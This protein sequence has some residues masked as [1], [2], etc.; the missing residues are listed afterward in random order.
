MAA[1][2]RGVVLYVRGH[3][4]R[5][6][7]LYAKLDAYALQDDGLDTYDANLALGR[8]GADRFLG[9]EMKL[10]VK[11]AERALAT[12]SAPMLPP[13]PGLFSTMTVWPSTVCS[14]LASSRASRSV[15]PPGA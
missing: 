1:R 5:G 9:G 3:E 11:A 8:L 6:I 15:V 12:A 4:G 7:G 10:D 14:L 13:A 2:G